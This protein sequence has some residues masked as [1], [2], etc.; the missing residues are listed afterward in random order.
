MHVWYQTMS[1]ERH[2]VRAQSGSRLL[3]QNSKS[4]FSVF[5]LGADSTVLSSFS[6]QALVIDTNSCGVSPFLKHF[7]K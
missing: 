4:H 3:L 7:K 2:I 1:N 6:L 5:L